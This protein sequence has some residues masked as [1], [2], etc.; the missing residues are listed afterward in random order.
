MS[1]KENNE[2]ETF[3]GFIDNHVYDI[4][5]GGI[6]ESLDGFIEYPIYEFFK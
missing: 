1:E 2:L 6:F 3:D 5:N 4:S